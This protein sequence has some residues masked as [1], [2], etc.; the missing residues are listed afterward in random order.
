Q[1]NQ[2]PEQLGV[3]VALSAAEADSEGETVEGSELRAMIAAGYDE[4]DS[5]HAWAQQQLNAL[6][7]DANPAWH[8]NV[9]LLAE[10]FV[11]FLDATDAAMFEN[12]LSEDVEEAGGAVNT[13]QT[14]FALG[15]GKNR[16]REALDKMPVEERKPVVQALI[17]TIKSM[18][19]TITTDTT[20]LRAIR[21]LEQMVSIGGY[22]QFDRWA[23]NFFSVL[24]ATI[25]LSPVRSIAGALR[26]TKTAAL[27]AEVLRRGAM[28]EESITAAGEAPRAS[29][30]PLMIE[31]KPTP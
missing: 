30:E 12:L 20:T 24:D 22:S 8:D 13:L 31:Y 11:P 26:G 9:K 3:K 4:V 17:G 28:A 14:L 10:S 2:T 1:T 27:D 21:N 15:E 19:G 29:G 5:Y 25:L 6:N 16:L 23:D 7:S 18:N